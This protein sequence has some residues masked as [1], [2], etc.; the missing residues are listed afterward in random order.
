M[1]VGR[2]DRQNSVMN[3][4]ARRLGRDM[5]VYKCR[6]SIPI[7]LVGIGLTLSALACEIQGLGAIQPKETPAGDRISDSTPAS[8][9]WILPETPSATSEIT[10]PTSTVVKTPTSTSVSPPTPTPASPAT[11]GFRPQTC[12]A[13]VADAD[14]MEVK[15]LLLVYNPTSGPA[16][17]D[18]T[19]QQIYSTFPSIDG[20]VKDYVNDRVDAGGGTFCIDV[21]EWYDLNE[22]PP[23][24]VERLAAPDGQL[25]IENYHWASPD[26][27][28][29]NAGFGME[30]AMVC[31]SVKFRVE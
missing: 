15:V 18:E 25:L 3:N 13:T 22:L 1:A 7:K 14:R 10:T 11:G 20:L 27:Y 5:N 24:A 17:G 9:Q 23:A 12:Q 16:C 21:V 2:M 6:L 31:A 19:L 29:H 26:V 28:F 8:I 30:Y 4:N